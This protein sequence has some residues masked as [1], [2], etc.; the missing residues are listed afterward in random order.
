M[1]L[2]LFGPRSVD[3]ITV[4][5]TKMQA[6]LEKASVAHRDAVEKAMRKEESAYLTYDA[7]ISGLYDVRDAITRGADNIVQSANRALMRFFNNRA[8][9]AVARSEYHADQMDRANIMAA[10]LRQFLGDRP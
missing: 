5:F 10:K 1:K 6:D 4:T 2:N 9:A 3:S 7:L 8:E